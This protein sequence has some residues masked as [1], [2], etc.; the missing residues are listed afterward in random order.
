MQTVSAELK[1]EE[2][3]KSFFSLK[4]TFCMKF[5]LTSD[6]FKTGLQRFLSILYIQEAA[7]LY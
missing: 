1:G 3:K 7:L 2:E 4:H 6:P 5:N